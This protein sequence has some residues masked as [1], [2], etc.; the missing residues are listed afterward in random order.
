VAQASW[1]R[2]PL[3][4]SPVMSDNPYPTRL[5][6]SCSGLQSMFVT[7]GMGLTRVDNDLMLCG[8]TTSVRWHE[9]H[10]VMVGKGERC[11]DRS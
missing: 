7:Y 5:A 4:L 8:Q 2:P 10:T 6:R 9:R 1:G 11:R 3:S